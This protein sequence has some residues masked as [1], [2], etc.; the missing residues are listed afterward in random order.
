[1][2]NFNVPNGMRPRMH[3]DGSPWAN[4]LNRYPITFN[5]G[6]AI[7]IGDAV[8]LVAGKLQKAAN[9]DQIRGVLVG[10]EQPR[11]ATYA[12]PYPAYWP[13]GGFTTL[14]SQDVYGL[15]VDDPN[16]LF[17]AQFGNSSSVPVIGDVSKYLKTF[18]NG[19][20]T[21]IGISGEGMD[22]STIS[23]TV[24]GFVWKFVKFVERVDNDL[25]SANSR[26]LFLPIL[27]DFRASG[28]AA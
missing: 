19:V 24:T 21:A 18:D 15:V 5:Y 2:A 7:G 20:N 8:K 1:M 10:F 4:A 27:H 13:A 17:E 23:T 6:T 3:V 9:T 22:Y 25:T 16:V 26:G 11:I 12:A 14:G 28:A